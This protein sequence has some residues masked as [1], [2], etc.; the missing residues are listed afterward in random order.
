M[1]PV[2][3]ITGRSVG[4]NKFADYDIGAPPYNPADVERKLK[5]LNLEMKCKNEVIEEQRKQLE[6][7]DVIIEEQRLRYEVNKPDIQRKVAKG[8][9]PLKPWSDLTGK[10]KGRTTQ[11][12]QER[13]LA[14]AE[15]REIGPLQLSGYLVHR[16]FFKILRFLKENIFAQ[17][18]CW[19]LIITIF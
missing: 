14:K 15:E 8:G 4:T 1:V 11:D 13:V 17:Y 6:E 16:Y 18:N 9:R 7:K 3:S 5:E 10:Q 19:F 12:L 2:F